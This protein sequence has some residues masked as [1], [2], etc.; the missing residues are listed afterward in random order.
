MAIPC[1]ITNHQKMN[2]MINT[3]EL[4]QINGVLKLK[5]VRYMLCIHLFNFNHK[6]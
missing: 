5:V 3:M 4:D 6:K 1:K 2:N